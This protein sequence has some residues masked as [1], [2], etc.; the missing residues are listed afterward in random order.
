MAAIGNTK[1][2]K[3]LEAK[4]Y[5]AVH[6]IG[7]GSAMFGVHDNSDIQNLV[8]TIYE[9]FN[10][11]ISAVYHGSAGLVNLKTRDGKYLVAGKVV[12]GYPDSYEDPSKAYFKHFPLLIEKTIKAHQGRFNYAPRNTAHIETDGRLVTGQNYLSSELVAAKVIELVEGG[13]E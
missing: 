9:D 6:Y 10:G 7:G 8:M 12:T 3:Q 5:Q 11:V 1:T 4:N 2:A 13:G